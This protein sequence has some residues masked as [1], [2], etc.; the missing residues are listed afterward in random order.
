MS[1]FSE[2]AIFA[3]KTENGEDNPD[4]NFAQQVQTI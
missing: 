2:K 4:E 1:Y 3:S